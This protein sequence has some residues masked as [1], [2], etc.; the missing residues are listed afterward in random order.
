MGGYE[1]GNG[2][3]FGVQGQI[4]SAAASGS[5]GV[6]GIASAGVQRLYSILGE[7]GSVAGSNSASILG[8][9]RPPTNTTGKI[10]AGVRG[11]DTS[12]G[13]LGLSPGFGVVGVVVNGAGAE[14]AE[15]Y[16]GYSGGSTNN[17]GVY[18]GV[19]TIGCS[20]CTKQFVDPHPTDPSKT[21][22]YVS[23]EGPEA[24]T[25][26][27]GTARLVRGVA[28]IAVPDH[29]RFVTDEDGMTVQLTAVGAP[30]SLYVESQGLNQIVIRGNRD[31]AVHYLVQGI[32]PAYKNFEPVVDGTEYAP[33]STNATMPAGY[34]QW[35]KDRLIQNGT[36][37]PDGKPNMETAKQLGWDKTWAKHEEQPK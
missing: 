19:G 26:F 12:I 18:A 32:R 35:A 20:G 23:L 13:V 17:Y 29:F 2:I 15:G 30:A 8:V 37:M 4:S 10:P 34:T 31:I 28:T 22:H 14:I 9:L 11:E 25:Y 33:Q 3:V 6:H 21:I 5:A 16:L 36:Y 27:R 1:S 7:G 24:G